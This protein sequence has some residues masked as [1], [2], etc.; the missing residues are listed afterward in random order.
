MFPNKSSKDELNNKQYYFVVVVVLK[1][2]LLHGGHL[3]YEN[4]PVLTS[5]EG[6][7]SESLI[8]STLL[9]LG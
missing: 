8:F 3:P 5:C 4:V 9:V 7:R 2:S 1:G 6:G